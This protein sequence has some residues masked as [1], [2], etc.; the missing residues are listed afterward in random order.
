MRERMSDVQ[1][2]IIGRFTAAVCDS[3]A[4]GTFN[5]YTGCTVL[6]AARS[7]RQSGVR[8]AD[9][10]IVVAGGDALCS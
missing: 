2:H 8:N 6:R 10:S 4:P 7:G 1:R 5:H 9:D 3:D